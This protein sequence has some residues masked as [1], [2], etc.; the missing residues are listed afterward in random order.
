MTLV[1]TS[2]CS[3]EKGDNEKK[4]KCKQIPRTAETRIDRQRFMPLKPLNLENRNRGTSLLKAD[5]KSHIPLETEAI[6]FLANLFLKQ[7]INS[8]Y[9]MVDFICTGELVLQGAK[10]EKNR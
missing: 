7:G 5:M 1:R 9:I 8:D 10:I 6:F 4:V 2:P 3:A